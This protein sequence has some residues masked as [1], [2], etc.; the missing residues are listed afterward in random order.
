MITPQQDIQ[1]IQEV[2]T[3]LRETPSD[4]TKLQKRTPPILDRN[5]LTEYRQF[6]G[7]RFK[8]TV[9]AFF[10][11]TSRLLPALREAAIQARDSVLIEI[12]L[13]LK[14]SSSRLGAKR[15]PI[16]CEAL[17]ERCYA[18]LLLDVSQRIADI[19]GEYKIL[20]QALTEIMNATETNNK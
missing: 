13:E 4:G 7:D 12:I 20:H 18:G 15:L 16:L 1:Q 6:M 2:N 17:Q 9:N 8:D 5:L 19:E 14:R 3:S 10:K 11:S